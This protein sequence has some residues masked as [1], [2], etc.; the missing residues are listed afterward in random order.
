MA[1][2][3]NY[4]TALIPAAIF[5]VTLSI[6]LLSPVHQ[7]TDSSY[8]MM[9]SENLL[10]HRSF[11][12]SHYNIPRGQPIW[13]RYYF[14]NGDIYQLEW[15]KGRLYYNFPLGSSVL[16][17]PFVAVLN[18]LGVSAVNSDR[19]YNGKGEERIEILLAAILMAALVCV[20]YFLA[21]LV[22]PTAH[23]VVIALGGGLG[24]QIWS[25]ASRSLWSDTW[26]SL[27]L[28]MVILMLFAAAN[29]RYRLRPILLATVLAWMY[30]VRP[31]F[32]VHIVGI[33]VYVFLYYRQTFVRYA[34][35]GAIWF[36]AFML[37]SWHLF[38]HLLPSYYRGNRLEFV[39][40]G[41][42]LTANLISPARGLLIYVPVLFFIGYLLLRY[43]RNIAYPRFV[44]LALAIIVAHLISISGLL[45]WWGGFSFGARF[46]TGLVPWFVL[47]AI[48]GF[49]AR[50]TAQSLKKVKA[51]WELVFGAC[52]LLMS[53][54][55]NGLGA[56][57]M[58]TWRWNTL[59]V[60]IDDDPDRNWDWHQP[61]FL[62]PFLHPRQPR[63]MGI[64]PSNR[65]EATRSEAVNY[66]WYGWSPA[67]ETFRWSEGK[68]ATIV[69]HANENQ[70]LTFRAKVHAF[71]IPNLRGLQRVA[72]KLN[73]Q[74][75]QNFDF[76]DPAPREITISLPADL[77]RAQN[78][79]EFVLPDAAAPSRLGTGDD[80]RE[81]AMAL[82]W[83]QFNSTGMTGKLDLR[84][85]DSVALTLPR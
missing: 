51:K 20:F 37:L 76:T 53:I 57:S 78:T 58:A 33:T 42:A 30:F 21:R 27:L 11:E 44:W 60:N 68:S 56:T 41:T 81:L 26:G 9:L 12:L 23:S 3:Q 79:L 45:H 65:V 29:G 61:Q 50:G 15:V 59:P 77:L 38:E 62:A 19:S 24:T 28:G 48:L 40:F 39:A 31:T 72:A 4:R 5:S 55:I 74:A 54:G 84:K 49:H 7:V 14:R 8:S 13:F 34:I 46:S 73:G 10:Y 43:R 66:L 71:I 47:L 25:T 85:S 18:A 67:E 83:F 17:A 64:A 16:S 82:Y 75:L 2:A 63:P 69:F 70:E 1:S 32:A 22:L 35:T 36:A 80:S 52:L 6:F